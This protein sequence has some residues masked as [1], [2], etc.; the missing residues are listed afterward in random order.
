MFELL[1]ALALGYLAGSVPSASL[2]ARSRGHDIFEVGSGNMGAMNTAR[3]LGWSLG[4]LVLLLDVGKG[5][6]A[7]WLA[8]GMAALAGAGP[9]ARLAMG[10]A[11]GVGAVAG[12]AWSAFEG[13][14]GG[15]A[16]ATMLGVALPLY[17]VAAL[18][19]LGVLVASVLLLR[20]V[21]L[22]SVLTLLVYPVVAL[23]A[24]ARRGWARDD[25]FAVVTGVAVLSLISIVKHVPTLRRDRRLF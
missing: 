23:A 11:A 24:L 1:A 9:D 25:A 20:R 14:R 15:K 21:G 19:A 3:N 12:H 8:L 7:V 6:L 5:A 10:L 2:V 16:L 22:A 4:V 13:L 17:P 18:Y